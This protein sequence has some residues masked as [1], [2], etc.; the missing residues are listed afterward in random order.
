MV[1]GDYRDFF[2]V[3][4][5]SAATLIG[6]LFVA[7]SVAGGRARTHAPLI[8]EFRAAAALFAF[9]NTFAVSLF[10][11]V[12]GSNIGYPAVVVSVIGILFAAAGLRTTLSLPIEQQHRRPQ[13]ALIFGLLVV[14][15]FELFYGIQLI[16]NWRRHSALDTLGY[17]LIA[18]MLIGIGR[19]WELVGDRDTGLLASI[20]VLIG[21]DP[22]SARAE[23]DPESDGREPGTQADGPIESHQP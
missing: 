12:P 22:R 4:A 21:H 19:S 11:L 18:S 13:F 1:T 7:M 17:V 20:G 16:Q 8:R 10:G 6:L 23:D 15:G 3:I 9:T 2:V 14:L 5:T